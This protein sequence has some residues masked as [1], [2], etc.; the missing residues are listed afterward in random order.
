MEKELIE[1]INK[2]LA[3]VLKMTDFP[4]INGVTQTPNGLTFLFHD[5]D[6]NRDV[7]TQWR[8]AI[9]PVIC[10]SHP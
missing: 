4:D 5:S 2:A 7:T 3:H 9:S 10:H 6:P 8:V 1:R